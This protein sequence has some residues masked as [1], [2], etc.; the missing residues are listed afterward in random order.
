MSTAARK[1][2][3]RAGIP[4]TKPAKTPTPVEDRTATKVAGD[5]KLRATLRTTAGDYRAA[6]AMLQKEAA[7]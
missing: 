2:R 5:R 3:K 4:F 7:L 1:A 6:V